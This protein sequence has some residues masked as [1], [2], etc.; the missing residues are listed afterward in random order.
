MIISR[1]NSKEG[2]EGLKF[3]LGSDLIG[4]GYSNYSLI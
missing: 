2:G 1:E 3:Q 4:Q